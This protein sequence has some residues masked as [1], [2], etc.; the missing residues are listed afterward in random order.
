MKWR[1]VKQPENTDISALKRRIVRQGV[2]CEQ[3][4]V[5]IRRQ[6][7][8]RSLHL[9]RGESPLRQAVSEGA[10]PIFAD[11]KIH[12]RSGKNRQNRLQHRP[13]GRISGKANADRHHQFTSFIIRISSS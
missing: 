8:H 13:N 3:L 12:I 9:L 7:V 5:L 11:E 6:G 1:S 4:R 2:N 10:H